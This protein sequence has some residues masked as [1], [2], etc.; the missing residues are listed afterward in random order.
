VLGLAFADSGTTTVS[1][2]APGGFAARVGLRKGDTLLAVA[3]RSVASETDVRHALD[4]FPADG[5]TPLEIRWS[6][7]RRPM[8][9]SAKPGGNWREYDISDRPSQGAI[10]PIL[11]IWEE[12]VPADARK[13]LGLATD[14]LAL[15]ISFLFDG[16]KWAATRGD[17]RLGDILVA[18]D[19]ERLPDFAPRQF[20]TWIRMHRSVGTVARFTVA[21]DGRTVDVSVPMVD[22]GPLEN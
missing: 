20:H 11:G 7:D 16:P 5:A 15:R 18:V 4:R 1:G 17:L 13:A 9:G 22:P 3:G 2:I 6:R 8:V 21:R 14:R 19:G 12:R 10:P